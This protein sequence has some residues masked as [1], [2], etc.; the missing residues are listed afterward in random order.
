MKVNYS[1]FAVEK[2]QK[3]IF[4]AG[5]TIRKEQQEE[6]KMDGWRK[7]AILI[8]EEL[9]FDG[10]VYVPEFSSMKDFV[11]KDE[12][13]E[14]EWEALHASDVVVFWVPRIFPDLPAMTTNVEF[15]FYINNGQTVLYGRPDDSYKNGYL[16]RLYNKVLNKVPQNNLRDLLKEAVE[17]L[18]KKERCMKLYVK[19]SSW[20]GWTEDYVPKIK[21]H[22]FELDSKED[23]IVKME[24]IYENGGYIDRPGFSFKIKKVRKDYVLIKT[25]CP[26][27]AEGVGINMLSRETEFKI[28]KDQPLTL[29]TLTFDYGDIYTFELK[30]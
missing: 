26:M 2:G 14:W 20:S 23:N 11:D 16:D 8:L 13:F 30:D 9:G 1:E 4:L 5:P 25:N 24:K 12:Q 21:N 6:L 22:V 15:G 19:E 18:D 28:V 17:L 27:S 7:E 29:T 3:S 10:I